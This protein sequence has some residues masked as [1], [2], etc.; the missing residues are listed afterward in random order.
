MIGIKAKVHRIRRV[1]KHYVENK[2]PQVFPTTARGDWVKSNAIPKRG[3]EPLTLAK[4]GLRLVFE[5]SMLGAKGTVGRNPES[6]LHKEKCLSRTGMCR[7]LTSSLSQHPLQ[8]IH[9]QSR[10]LLVK[11]IKH[12]HHHDIE[13]FIN[14]CMYQEWFGK[15][16]LTAAQIVVR[17]YP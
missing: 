5:M 16:I 14:K 8:L 13:L 2:T 9:C 12:N 11:D 10:T 6:H 3:L 4:V 7:P 17:I 1:E 15:H